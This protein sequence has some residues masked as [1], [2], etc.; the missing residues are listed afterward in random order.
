MSAAY[1][2][3]RRPRRTREEPIGYVPPT[4]FSRVRLPSGVD[5][6]VIGYPARAPHDANIAM[7]IDRPDGRMVGIVRIYPGEL[8]DIAERAL[9]CARHGSGHNTVIGA[10]DGGE[11][12]IKVAVRQYEEKRLILFLRVNRDG[13]AVS[14]PMRITP[15]EYLAF[16]H[17][18]SWLR[19][20][21]T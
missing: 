5:R 15:D 19:N 9:D 11:I 8:L 16:E 17:A 14:K 1:S 20:E 4:T 2:L 7:A 10:F 21:T 12:T 18:L 3:P 13:E 6:V